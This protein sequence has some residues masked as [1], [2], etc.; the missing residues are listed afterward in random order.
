MAT[1]IR[2]SRHGKKKMPFYRIVVQD[3]R[4][5]RD[6]RFV[7]HIGSF[8][9]TKGR[10]TLVVQKDRLEYWLATGA[11]LSDTLKSRIK[12][13]NRQNAAST[14]AAPTPAPADKKKSKEA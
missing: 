4:A 3:S 5:P 2:L 7:E 12:I 11:Q 13:W 9:P 14:P 10:D 8:D 6:G 1:V